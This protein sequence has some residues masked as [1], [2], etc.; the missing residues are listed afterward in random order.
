MERVT[1]LL[2]QPKRKYERNI[3]GGCRRE[4]GDAIVTTESEGK[5]MDMAGIRQSCGII[6]FQ[7]ILGSNGVV[8]MPSPH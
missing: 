8:F 3:C 4:R 2:V 7:I 1:L 5:Y 6:N